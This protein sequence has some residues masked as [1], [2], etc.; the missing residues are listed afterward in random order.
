MKIAL[1]TPKNGLF[2]LQL[3]SKMFSPLYLE[4]LIQV[5][6]LVTPL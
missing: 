3:P 1:A 4:N 6:K 2:I 5:P